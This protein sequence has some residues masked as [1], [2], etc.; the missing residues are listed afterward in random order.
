VHNADYVVDSLCR[1]LRHL[2]LHPQAPSFLAA[3]LR[4][5]GAAPDLLPLLEEPMRGIVLELEIPARRNHP[6]YTVPLLQALREIAKAA[7]LEGAAM[8]S[9]VSKVAVSLKSSL[10]GIAIDK[11][12]KTMENVID[13]EIPDVDGMITQVQD[14]ER[15]QNSVAAVATS[16]L[17]ASAPLLASR[18]S[19]TCLLVLDTIEDGVAGL[20]DIEAAFPHLQAQRSA[21]EEFLKRHGD[22][23]GDAEEIQPFGSRDDESVRN[24]I[25]LPSMNR[26]WPHL[27]S[28]LRQSQPSVIERALA[29]IASATANCGGHFF[30]RRMEKDALPLLLKLLREGPLI[31]AVHTSDMLRPKTSSE[32]MLLRRQG[33]DYG[34]S[35]TS[36]AVVLRVQEAV[37]KCISAIAGG[38]KSAAA[39]DTVYKPLV[40]LVVGLACKQQA[41]FPAA[42]DA[43]LALSHMDADL[44]WL[45]VADLA[46]GGEHKHRESP[47]EEFPGFEQVF[48][49]LSSPKDALWVQYSC[50]DADASVERK[51]AWELLAK[52]EQYI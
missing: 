26:I 32:L 50:F 13:S 52:L 37:L 42:A 8:L 27:V 38:Q 3:I 29:V 20:A 16:C 2:E 9:E 39:M 1:Q 24:N 23:H 6:A 44:V 46:Y 45:L 17:H 49:V 10:Q 11:G 4:H 12:L 48:P 22:G 36:L 34:E 21:V 7:R 40:A 33:R 18:D 5:T 35:G 25:L 47:G 31:H 51:A 19:H 28:C 30:S 41:L 43:L 15:R 14:T